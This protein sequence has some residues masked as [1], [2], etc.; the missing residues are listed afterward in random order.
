MKNIFDIFVF[1]IYTDI[2]IFE[3]ALKINKLTEFLLFS[4]VYLS[5][6]CKKTK[7]FLCLKVLP[8]WNQTRAPSWTCCVAYSTS[9]PPTAFYN[10]QKLNLCSKTNIKKTAWVNPWPFTLEN[11]RNYTGIIELGR[12][13]NSFHSCKLNVY[14]YPLILEHS[15]RLKTTFSCGYGLFKLGGRVTPTKW[16]S[17]D[18]SKL[19]QMLMCY[20]FMQTDIIY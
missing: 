4:A 20:L 8:P 18:N 1:V 7:V 5:S 11:T 6:R 14:H 17:K 19:L 15:H 3:L 2:Y 10:I 9:R 13:G 12:N 16:A